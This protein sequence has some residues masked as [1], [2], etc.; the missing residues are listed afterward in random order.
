MCGTSDFFPTPSYPAL[1]AAA[2]ADAAAPARAFTPYSATHGMMLLG[3]AALTVLLVVLRRRAR[4]AR[5]ARQLD[6]ALAVAGLT[7]WAAYKV[8]SFLPGNLLWEYSL[9]LQMCDCAGLFAPLVLLTNA[10]PLRALLYFWGFAFSSLGLIL[11]DLHQGPATLKFWLFW[12]SHGA[13][14]GTAAYDL[15]ARGFRPTWRDYGT[16]AAASALYVLLVFPFNAY[17]GFSYG[18]SG[19]DRPRQPPLLDLLGTWPTRVLWICVLGAVILAILQLPW[20]VARRVAARRNRSDGVRH[21]PQG[22]T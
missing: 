4:D 6:V 9:P 1:A 8:W 14:V 19:P 3:L 13:I 16:A 22:V 21:V 15:A 18:Y 5:A 12:L 10:R 20:E 11:P 7:V 2:L 17:T